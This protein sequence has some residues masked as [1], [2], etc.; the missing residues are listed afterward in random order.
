[1]KFYV[2]RDQFTLKQTQQKIAEMFNTHGWLKLTPSTQKR[3]LDANSL[4]HV[5]YAEIARQMGDQTA[6]EYKLTCKLHH[7]VPILR[8]DS[9]EFREF[10]NKFFLKLTYE[11]KLEAM[12]WLSVSS[13]MSKEQMSEYMTAIQN[14]YGPKGVVLSNA[15]EAAGI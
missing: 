1:L 7:G 12:K 11:E 5:W 15:K 4:S 6:H 13:T 2:V 8:R 9:E 14:F 10:Y 3:S